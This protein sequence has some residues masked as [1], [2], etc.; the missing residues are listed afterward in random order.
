MNIIIL[1][2]RDIRH[3]LAG[4]AE[5]S[6]F[7]HAKYWTKNGA[8]V[9]WF[10]SSFR[11]GEKKENINGIIV[12]RCGSHYTVH[13]YAFLY[14]IIGKFG[15]I[16]V[17]VDS[18]HFVPFFTPLYVQK[19]RIIA[20]INEVARNLWFSNLPII[21]SIIGY[22]LEFWFFKIYR[23]IIFIT[24]SHSTKRE[25]GEY[26]IPLKQIQVIHHGIYLHKNQNIKKEKNPT[27]IFLGRIAKDKGIQ[28]AICA[29]SNVKCQMSRLRQ[30]FGGQAKLK[31]W[32]VGKS[33]KDRDL[34]LVKQMVKDFG[35]DDI[36]TFFGLVSEKKKF[37]LLKR[38]WVLIHPSIKEG[39]GLTVIEAASQGTPTVGYDVEGLR[40]S[41]I[42]NKT[43]ILVQKKP[44][45][46]A[47][48]IMRIMKD[49]KLYNNLRREGMKRSKQF[50]WSKSGRESWMLL[51]K[52]V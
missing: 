19:I 5:I 44:E 48:A 11:G 9:I 32:V 26:G 34:I 29:M 22:H 41:I 35:I 4:G 21:F 51:R 49:K 3:P 13:I 6:L 8:N 45:R 28:D 38:A 37:E 31:F 10:A 16:D 39:W 27:V 7:E 46:L 17:V 2:W 1:N 43:G 36:T 15:K 50:R 23:K 30:D 18:F 25:L 52:N 47:E 20:L 14:Y 40:D 12:I 42:H 24:G 33:E